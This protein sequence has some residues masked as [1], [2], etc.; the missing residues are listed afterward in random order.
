VAICQIY[1]AFDF[2]FLRRPL[3]LALALGLIGLIALRRYHLN[4]LSTT[5][6]RALHDI[7]TGVFGRAYSEVWAGYF[8][9]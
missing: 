9:H 6:S 7:S 4:D 1:V 3:A 8:T 2:L 5:G